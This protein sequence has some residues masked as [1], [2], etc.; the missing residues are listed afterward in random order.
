[1]TVVVVFE[2]R[3]AG[4]EL[5]EES[6][7]RAAGLVNSYIEKGYSVGLR[8]LSS[9]IAHAP[10][11]GQLMRLLSELALIGPEHEDGQPSV[12]AVRS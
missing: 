5:F 7:D 11:R 12:K 10:G 2:N 1:M 4:D 8:T 6:V 3:G 9:E